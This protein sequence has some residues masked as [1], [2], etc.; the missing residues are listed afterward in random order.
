MH[1]LSFSIH[2]L[3]T[4]DKNHFTVVKLNWYSELI[5]SALAIYICTL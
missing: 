5:E 4:S 3:V 1:L 2:I